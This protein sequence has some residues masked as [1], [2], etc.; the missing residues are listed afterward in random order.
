[1]LDRYFNL[2]NKS[3]WQALIRLF[4]NLVVA[5]FFGLPCGNSSFRRDGAVHVAGQLTS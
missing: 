2:T 1:V 4:G 3:N 5:Y